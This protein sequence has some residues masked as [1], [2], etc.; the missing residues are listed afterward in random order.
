MLI[1]RLVQQFKFSLLPPLSTPSTFSE[2]P[3]AYSSALQSPTNK[4]TVS[5]ASAQYNHTASQSSSLHS[6]W[7]NQTAGGN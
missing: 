3:P 7:C 6:S 1:M 5:P 2:P 4:T